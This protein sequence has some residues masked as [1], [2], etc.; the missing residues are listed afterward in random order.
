MLKK[1]TTAVQSIIKSIKKIPNTFK[2]LQ[3]S[4]FSKQG[5]RKS[6]FGSSSYGKIANEV[7][8]DAVKIELS[9]DLL[10]NLKT[11]IGLILQYQNEGNT[12]E[13]GRLY[14]ELCRDKQYK[15]LEDHE[16][17]ISLNNAEQKLSI[18]RILEHL[19][20]FDELKVLE[21][22]TIES[23]VMVI[24]QQYLKCQE[25]QSPKS[26]VMQANEVKKLVADLEK[27]INLR[28]CNDTH[29]NFRELSPKATSTKMI[30]S[31]EESI[32]AISSA[33]HYIKSKLT[34]IFTSPL[35]S[36][37]E[38]KFT[39]KVLGLHHRQSSRSSN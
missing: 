8:D 39:E 12:K 9:T 38:I 10:A 30:F 21:A 31:P 20:T 28:Y 4:L 1:L 16:I 3:N 14:T 15:I 2:N 13:A 6:S 37:Q 35:K 11:K 7:I 36:R 18:K 33:I 24:Q 25:A 26:K 29:F 34:D 19:D 17:Q 22:T 5:R 32:I 27:M 23:R